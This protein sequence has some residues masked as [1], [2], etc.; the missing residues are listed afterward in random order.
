[1]QREIG[2]QGVPEGGPGEEATLTLRSPVTCSSVGLVLVLVPSPEPPGMLHWTTRTKERGAVTA[3][4]LWSPCALFWQ[5]DHSCSRSLKWQLLSLGNAVH[6]AGR[7]WTSVS[8]ASSSQ[9]IQWWDLCAERRYNFSAVNGAS[10][11]L[12]VM[13]EPPG[14][15]NETLS[16]RCH[17]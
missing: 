7:R 17:S 5:K 13:E 12:L 8:W 9:S 10:R 14:A 15:L 3:V 11:L 4:G 6:K 16:W 1:M 2:R